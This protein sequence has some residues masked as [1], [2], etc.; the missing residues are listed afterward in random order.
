MSNAGYG[1]APAYSPTGNGGA[2]NANGYYDGPGAAAEVDGMGTSEMPAP[3]T[4]YARNQ[5]LRSEAQ[6]LPASD[7][8][9]SR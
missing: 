7:S 6:E 1:P 8:W 2:M 3:T 4:K 9:T 5:A